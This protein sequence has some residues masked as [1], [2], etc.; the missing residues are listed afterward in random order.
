[1]GTGAETG[2]AWVA[3][4]RARLAEDKEIAWA[5]LTVCRDSRLPWPP[6][7][8]PGNGGPALTEYL[9]RFWLARA[10]R[11]A[12]ATGA[13]LDAYEASVRSVG[14]YLS[15]SLLRLVQAAA[16][17]WAGH[18]DYPGTLSAPVVQVAAPSVSG[19]GVLSAIPRAVQQ[20]GGTHDQP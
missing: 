9:R 11:Q 5:A 8:P 20:R 13:L 15:V 7:Q 19:A 2:P 1:M 3:F 4:V 16:A 14:P 18:P 12:E 6:E 10:L 17:V